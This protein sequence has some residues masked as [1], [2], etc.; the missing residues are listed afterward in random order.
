VK[1]TAA[2]TEQS[3]S[4]RQNLAHQDVMLMQIVLSEYMLTTHC[5]GCHLPLQFAGTVVHEM[6]YQYHACYQY[7]PQESMY[8]L[9][10]YLLQLFLASNHLRSTVQSDK[11]HEQASEKSAVIQHSR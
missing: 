4:L 11:V 8:Y 2:A 1:A 5:Y 9:A 10:V 6:V 7:Q 3:I